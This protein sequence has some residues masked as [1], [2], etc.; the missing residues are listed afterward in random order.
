MDEE[1]EISSAY[2]EHIPLDNIAGYQ[3]EPENESASDH[4][5]E[6]DEEENVDLQ[7]DSQ[8]SDST[9][10][11]QDSD[12]DENDRVGNVDWCLCGQ[13]DNT[14]LVNTKE[15]T[16]CHEVTKK[17]RVQIG[18]CIDLA[19]CQNMQLDWQLV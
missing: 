12:G 3:H 6:F 19:G 14:Y 7:C 5:D 10:S 13:C 16:C 4:E 11:S 2:Q 9:V 8:D 1:Q 17:N 15:Y 18:K